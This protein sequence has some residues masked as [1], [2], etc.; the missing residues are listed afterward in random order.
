ML[1]NESPT[2]K[3]LIG[4]RHNGSLT[5]KQIL[6]LFTYDEVIGKRIDELIQ[7]KWIGK[8][9][10]TFFVTKRGKHIASF[11]TL[12]RRLLGLSEGG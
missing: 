4:L 8:Y 3:I 2:T 5:E 9:N 1:G 11:F 10:D 7:S 6:S 12:Y